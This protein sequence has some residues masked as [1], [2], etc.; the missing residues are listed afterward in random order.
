MRI[1]LIIRQL[2]SC[3]GMVMAIL[4]LAGCTAAYQIRDEHGM[5]IQ[6]TV[7]NVS[8]GIVAYHKKY[9]QLPEALRQLVPEFISELPDG[10]ALSYNSK[11]RSLGFSYSP[12]LWT[13][14]V[15]TCTTD[16]EQIAW[17]CVRY[18]L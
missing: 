10:I 4:A 1:A 2:S 18:L 17:A 5:E 13:G 7:E 8:A 14:R 6:R 15:V 16:V 9:G 12:N 3:T 11:Q